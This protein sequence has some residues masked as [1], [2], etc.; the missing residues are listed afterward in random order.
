MWGVYFKEWF[1]HTMNKM[2]WE[3]HLKLT[4]ELHRYMEW[5]NLFQWSI[6]CSAK[7]HSPNRPSRASDEGLKN[8]HYKLFQ[9]SQFCVQSTHTLHTFNKSWCAY[10]A[11]VCFPSYPQLQHICTQI[12]EKWHFDHLFKNKTWCCR[13]QVWRAFAFSVPT[14][15]STPPWQMFWF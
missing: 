13:E 9:T 7:D 2:W 11:Y 8:K 10:S 4:F 5:W 14:P 1:D 6:M 3:I 15:G 12:S